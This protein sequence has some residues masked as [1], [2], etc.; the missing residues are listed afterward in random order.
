MWPWGWGYGR[1]YWHRHD[2]AEEIL[3]QRFAKGEITKEQFDQMLK[4]LGHSR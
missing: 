1:G 3:R 2:E 4:D